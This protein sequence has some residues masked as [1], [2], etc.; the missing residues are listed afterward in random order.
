S[1]ID[2]V[3]LQARLEDHD[4]PPEP[5]REGDLGQRPPAAADRDHGVAGRRDGEVPHMPEPGGDSVVDPLVRVAAARPGENADRG[6]SSSLRA[7][8]RGRH[9]L[10]EPAGGTLEPRH[11]VGPLR[12]MCPHAELLLGRLEALDAEQHVATIRA[13]TETIAV[14]YDQAVLALGSYPRALPIPGLAEHGLGFKDLADAIYLRNHVLRQLEHAAAEKDRQRAEAHLTFVFI[15]AGYAGVEALAELSDLVRDA[16]RYYPEFQ[17][18]RMRWV[19]VDAAPKILPEI[20]T[21]LGEYAAR[22]LAG[23]GVEIRTS[24]TLTSVGPGA[25]ALSGGGRIA[26]HTLVWTAGAPPLPHARPGRHA[27]PLQGDRPGPRR[28]PAWVHRL[29]RDE[30]VPPLPAA[31]LLE[32][33]TRRDR[34][35]GRPPLPKGHRRAGHA[36]APEEARR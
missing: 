23:R 11:A 34:L 22:Q 7:A 17:R 24:T 14:H 30:D 20:P 1:A 26:T 18:P 6:A 3:H 35:D 32:E 5:L 25:V 9:H 31:A 36:R 4:R 27:R 8:H 12:M 19:L 10:A 33:A 16:L 21:R 29:V 15:G 13:G 2:A 28:A